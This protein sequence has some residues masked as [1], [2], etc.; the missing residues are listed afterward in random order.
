MGM[1]KV[2]NSDNR[3]STHKEPSAV[4]K[5]ITGVYASALTFASTAVITF[6]AT[7]TL[8]KKIADAAT[9]AY[10]NIK[11][12]FDICAVLA[13]AISLLLLLFGRSDKTAEP[14]YKAIK[15]VIVAFVVF[16]SLGWL[17]PW[18]KSISGF[19]D[20]VASISSGFIPQFKNLILMY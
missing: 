3:L 15:I 4:G 13:L 18:I 19:Q 17:I 11:D 5:V 2:M 14:S 8:G 6:A 16:H 10:Q 12:A 9:Y 7:D 20:Y 1:T